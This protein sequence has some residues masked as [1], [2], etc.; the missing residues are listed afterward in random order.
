MKSDCH[1]YDSCRK[2]VYRCTSR[3]PEYRKRIDT[4][5]KGKKKN[6]SK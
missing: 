1:K 2:P 6:A 4:S 5:V 3:C